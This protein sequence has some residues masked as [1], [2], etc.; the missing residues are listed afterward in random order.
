MALI[1]AIETSGNNCS[2]CLASKGK[3]LET[4]DHA[5]MHHAKVVTGFIQEVL[6]ETGKQMASID[7]IALSCGPGSFTGLRIGTST[8]KGLCYALDI[9]LIAIP[10]LAAIAH[11]LLLNTKDMDALYMPMIEARKS[12]V[13]AA[14][15]NSSGECLYGPYV[16]DLDSNFI[17][18]S[19]SNKTFVIG[20]PDALRVGDIHS[21]AGASLVQTSKMSSIHLIPIAEKY[22]DKN[23]FESVIV[24]E[25]FYL[26]DVYI[27]KS[28]KKYF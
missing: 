8:A 26:K 23:I 22:Y 28:N 20:G 19:Y 25:P 13:Y 4:K 11:Q 2:V 16:A 3:V 27:S 1:L 21:A 18:V 5:G 14:I 15:Y 17:P 10:T 12:E 7:A 24:Y 6:E 9:P